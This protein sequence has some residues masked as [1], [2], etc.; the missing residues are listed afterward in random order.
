L[1]TLPS[2]FITESSVTPADIVQEQDILTFFMEDI[3]ALLNAYEP[4]KIENKP[5]VAKQLAEIKANR[6]NMMREQ[7]EKEAQYKET[8]MKLQNLQNPQNLQ[9]KMNEMSLVIQQLT[10]ENNQL[11]DKLKYLEDKI[12]IIIGEKIQKKNNEG[13]A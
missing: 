11:K 6:E 10:Q 7:M 8:M 9:S 5:D 13:N 3:D 4:G 1:Q 2:P 12:K